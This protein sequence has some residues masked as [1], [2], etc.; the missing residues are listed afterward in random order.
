MRRRIP[1]APSAKNTAG[2]NLAQRNELS[3]PLKNDETERMLAMSRKSQQSPAEEQISRRAYEMYV[4]RGSWD[5]ND[6]GDWLAAE[7]ELSEQYSSSSQ[8]A[9][10]V[11][12][13][14]GQ[15]ALVSEAD[16]KHGSPAHRDR[17]N[18]SRELSGDAHAR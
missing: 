4:G 8:K 12:A 9:K 10:M 14:R 1:N 13:G 11:A 15:S 5:G 2:L 18:P 6:I 7:R 17:I 16:T 3:N